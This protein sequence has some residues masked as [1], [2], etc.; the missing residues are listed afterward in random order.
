MT[1]VSNPGNKTLGSQLKQEARPPA[2]NPHQHDTSNIAESQLK[3]KAQLQTKGP[4]QHDTRNKRTRQSAK[5]RC[6]ATSLK[7]SPARH[8]HRSQETEHQ[9]ASRSKSASKLPEALT[10]MTQASDP[11]S[12]TLE[13]QLKQED[14]QTAQS[15]RQHDTSI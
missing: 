3:R 8:K 5:A 7:P 11:G 14:R 4:D 10:S 6:Q 12:K 15:P 1:Q 2:R 9:G 13:G